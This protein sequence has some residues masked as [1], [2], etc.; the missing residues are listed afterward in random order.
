MTAAENDSKDKRTSYTTGQ[1]AKKA[2]VTVRTVRFY[3]EKGLL[4]PEY[5]TES[6]ARRYT[7]ED[8]VRLQQILLFK[9]LGF[10]LEEIREMTLGSMDPEHLLR[11]LEIQKKLLGE[12]IEQMQSMEAVMDR[13]AGQLRRKETGKASGSG[14]NPA[15]PSAD[16]N[17]MMQLLRLTTMEETMHAQYRD[18]SNVSTRIRLHRDYS[19][20]PEG[21]FP[22]V[23]RH[24]GIREL[25]C[26]SS[27]ERGGA[28]QLDYEAPRILEV[29][30]GNGAL[31]T[32]NID[33]VPQNLS[34]TLSDIS[35]GMLRDAK[36]NIREA[37]HRSVDA[38]STPRMFR[39][40][41]FDCAHIPCE[42]NTFDLVIANHMLFYCSDLG[43]ALREIR[44]VLKPG[45]ALLATTYSGKH[46][47]E[48]TSLVQKFNPE[49]SL[50]ADALW[51][52]FGL[53]NGEEILKGVFGSSARVTLLRCPDAIEISDPEPLI[54]Y[55][56]SCHGNQNR[57]LLDKYRKFQE[58]VA[59]EVKGGFHIT[60]D[61]GLFRVE[62]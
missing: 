9:Y 46:M 54:A 60:K 3:D 27:P 61:A 8:F 1:F 10:S 44:R 2:H 39:T 57:I 16:W 62:K 18:A 30:C 7:D 19:T 47:R 38:L 17:A 52:R 6:G 14:R 42:K 33:R 36:E 26:Q 48:I 28:V 40:K 50:S 51:K 13:L 15:G 53:E 5:R 49:I 37:Y 45:G 58:F 4:K 24:S 59:R 34:I 25:A 32:E 56:L 22:W 31:W 20:N 43:Q 55:I 35:E 29:G 23:F 21:W 41:A 12:R 11:S